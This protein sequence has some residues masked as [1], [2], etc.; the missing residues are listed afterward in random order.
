MSDL[1]RLVLI[2]VLAALAMLAGCAPRSPP[3]PPQVEPVFPRLSPEEAAQLIPERIPDRAGW[4]ADVL[5]A[6]D[7]IGVNP[8]RNSVCEVLSI[9]QQE[10]GFQAN[11]VVPNLAHIVHARLEAYASKLGPLGNPALHEVLRGVA[12]GHAPGHKAGSGESF[13]QR[14]SKVR[15]ERDVDVLFR[16]LL[17]YYR[18]KFPTTYGVVNGLEDLFS[19]RTLEDLNPVT[20]V[21]SMQVS[22]AFA[23]ALAKQQGEDPA[24]VRDSLYTRAGGLKYGTARLLGWEA[25]YDQPLYRFA[26]YNAGFYSSRNAALQKQLARLTGYALTPD[27]DLLAY[28]KA[29]RP[30]DQDSQSLKVLFAFRARF[31]NDLSER[32][33]RKDLLLEKTVDFEGTDTYRAVKRAYAQLTGETPASAL[34]PTVSLNSPKMTKPRSTAWFAESV[35]NRFTACMNGRLP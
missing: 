31:A 1:R 14:L 23:E 20:T 30:L 32:R 24:A 28:D 16:D 10:S 4:A 12:P 17:A 34:V 22:V 7:G 8:S 35:N 11:P 6:L 9:V 33:I 3:L 15:T 13:E 5:S 27:G 2:P 26:D 21:G 19:A 18:A 25:S 29:G